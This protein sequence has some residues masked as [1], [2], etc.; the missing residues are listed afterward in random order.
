MSHRQTQHHGRSE[1]DDAVPQGTDA[2]GEVQVRS[3]TVAGIEDAHEVSRL[4]DENEGY[5]RS[6]HRDPQSGA[7]RGPKTDQ[8][9]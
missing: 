6:D 9:R 1:G 7:S 8:G 5:D 4:I 3:E 2:E